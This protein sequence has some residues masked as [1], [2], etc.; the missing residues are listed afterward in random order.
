M[1]R[2]LSLAEDQD[3]GLAKIGEIANESQIENLATDN[4]DHLDLP[5]SERCEN[6]RFPHNP[7]EPILTFPNQCESVLS[8]FISGSVLSRL[9]IFGNS[10][11]FWQFPCV[12]LPLCSTS[13]TEIRSLVPSGKSDFRVHTL[14]GV[15]CCM[16]A[17]SLKP[18]R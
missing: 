17:L 1:A 3:S 12:S 8:V 16:T 7:S 6:C 11:R 2:E 9:P 14:P 4:T 10:G 5:G 15:T 18:L 13:P